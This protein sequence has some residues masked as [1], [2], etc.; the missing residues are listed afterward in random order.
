MARPKKTSES[1]QP[2]RLTIINLKG[3]QE[4]ADWLEAVHKKTHI[5][6]SVIVRLALSQWAATNGLSAFPPLDSEDDQ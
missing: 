3:T 4:Q 2:L 1:S 5:A 6:K